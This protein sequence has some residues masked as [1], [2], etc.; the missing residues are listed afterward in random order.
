MAITW[1]ML[2]WRYF[3]VPST[4]PRNIP[5]IPIWVNVYAMWYDM[6]PIDLYNAFYREPLEKHGA[7]TIWFTGVWCVIVT[8]PEYIVDIFRNDDM[9][10]KV[11]VNRRGNGSL[12]AIFSGENIINASKPV[13]NTFTNVMKPGLLKTFDQGAIHKKAMKVPERLLQAQ[14]E[15]G[16]RCGVDVHYWMN[17]FTQDVM[18]LCLFDIDLQALDEPI[19]PY[20]PLIDHIV[21][22][23]FTRWA[24]YFPKMDIPGRHLLSRRRVLQEI[25]EFDSQLDGILESTATHDAK[26]QPKVLSHLLKQA[27]DDGRITYAQFRTNLRMSFMV[28][29][30][31]AA[32]FLSSV[33]LALGNDP[34]VQDALRA[35]ALLASPDDIQNLPYLTSVIY[36]VLRLY[37]PVTEIIN[38]TAAEPVSIGGK[39]PVRPGTW[40]GF[41]SYGV[42][43]NPAI[44]GSDA[45]DLKPERWGSNLKDIQAAFRLRSTRGHYIPFSLHA[46][47]C[48]G[49]GLVLMEVK[50]VLFEIVRRLRWTV[51]P[52]S[53]INLGVVMFTLPL[54]LRIL[55]EELG[56]DGGAG[57]VAGNVE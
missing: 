3:R 24:L 11:G 39:V 45:R 36:E 53:R 13:W 31:T 56:D 32:N 23:I 40:I 19:V 8:H 42:H 21:P 57:A 28:G 14:L 34:A 29:H 35:E 38:H 20:A 55:V 12:I 30:D 49:Q 54:G 47:K 7:I 2:I 27:Y 6:S 15:L 26:E 48:L 43:T 18:G 22:V 25:A 51:D 9:Y 52:E 4:I 5:R 33:I 17:K 50:L 41:N 46:R 44:W 16:P 1:A 37:P 10:P